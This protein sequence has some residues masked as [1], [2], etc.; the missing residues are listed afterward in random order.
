MA[1]KCY[2]RNVR[3]LVLHVRRPVLPLIFGD[4][5]HRL[6]QFNVRAY[7]LDLR[8]LFL[9]RRSET[10]DFVLQ[11]GDNASCSCT[12]RCSLRNSLSNIAL[13]IS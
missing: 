8:G 3:F 4:L 1:V 6:I 9:D 10:G 13:I 2:P 11:L 7:F 12:V 5:C